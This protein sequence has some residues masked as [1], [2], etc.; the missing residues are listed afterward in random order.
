MK[1]DKRHLVSKKI[2]DRI[3]VRL[4]CLFSSE[5]LKNYFRVGV[6][7]Q[8]VHGRRIGRVSSN[9]PLLDSSRIAHSRESGTSKGLHVDYGRWLDDKD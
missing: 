6:D 4:R 3:T 5:P 8:V 1:P 2:G 7:A 9:G